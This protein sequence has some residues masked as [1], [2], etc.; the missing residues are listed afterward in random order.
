MAEWT[1]EARTY[2]EGYLSQVRALA[3]Q[4]GDDADEIAADLRAHIVREAEAG[5]GAVVTLDDLRRTLALTGAPEQV[6]GVESTLGA[7]HEAA[8]EEPAPHPVHVTVSP[9]AERKWFPWGCIAV[10]IAPLVGLILLAVFGMVVAIALPSFSR[11]RESTSRARCAQELKEAA[12][13][14]SAAAEKSDGFYPCLSPE[15]R[16]VEELAADTQRAQDPT[17]G[18]LSLAEIKELQERRANTVAH[19]FIYLSH[20]VLDEAAAKTYAKQWRSAGD[21]APTDFVPVAADGKAF[22]RLRIGAEEDSVTALAE[23]PVL[24]EVP[25]MHTPEG[26]NVL[27]LDGRVVFLRLGEKFP[28]TPGFFE[29]FGVSLNGHSQR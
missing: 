14:L 1:P 23:I 9:P 7:R 28:M 11:A 22:G 10:L 2:L 27:F 3:L 16:S 5:A 19:R 12:F 24:V 20:T 6:V 25:A 4:Q 21:L 13:A 17:A 15:P 8:A 26:G 29:A 18:R